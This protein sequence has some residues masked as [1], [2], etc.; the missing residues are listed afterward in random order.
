MRQKIR[1]ASPDCRRLFLPN[2]RIKNQRYC[3]RKEC[4]L[5]RKGLWQR[6]KMKSDPDYRYDHK[7][8]QQCWKEQHPDY[9]RQYRNNHPDYVQRNR[10][11]QK[12]RDLKR[13][14]GMLAKM[15]ASSPVSPL[16]AG[17]YYVIPSTEDLAKMDALLPTYFLIPNSYASLAKMDSNDLHPFPGVEFRAKEV[18]SR[19]RKNPPL[20][21]ASP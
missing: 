21:R 13:R 12:V 19:D 6:Q 7:D 2:P 11:Q 1:C 3:R 16:K 9:W 18:A 4:Q 5:L 8:A 20:P 10:L 15:D 14:G 17:S